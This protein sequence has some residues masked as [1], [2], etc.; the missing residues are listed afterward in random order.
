MKNDE[1]ESGTVNFLASLYETLTFQ[2]TVWHP[3]F[4]GYE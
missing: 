4:E 2:D 3:L 1:V